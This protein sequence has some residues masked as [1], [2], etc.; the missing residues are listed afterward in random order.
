MFENEKDLQNEIQ[1]NTSLQKDICSL[2]D[3]DFDKC[4]FVGEDSYI[5]RITADFSIFENGKIK[6]I[7]ECKGGK[8]NVTDYIRGIGQI[9]QYEYFAEQKLSGKKYEFVEMSD[10]SSVYI[11]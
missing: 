4:K 11:F 10:F 7:M 5:N 1:T 6:A 3:I 8:I 9:F 2:L